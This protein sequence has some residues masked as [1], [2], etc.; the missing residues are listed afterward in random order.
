MGNHRT[1]PEVVEALRT[2][3]GSAVD[4]NSTT[5][6]QAYF[7]SATY[8]PK[9]K[10]IIRSA[11]SLQRQSGQESACRPTLY[12]VCHRGDDYPHHRPLP[13][14]PPAGP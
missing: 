11:T 7:Y 10:I 3:T 4:R 5:L 8:F 6:R 1:R 9:E 13:L 14:H 2:G 12:M